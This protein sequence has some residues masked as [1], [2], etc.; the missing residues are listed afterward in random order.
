M[1]LCMRP[2]AHECGRHHSGVVRVSSYSELGELLAI[3]SIEHLS[4][5]INAASISVVYDVALAHEVLWFSGP[6]AKS[7]A[8]SSQQH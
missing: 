3:G 4:Q 2:R 1:V 5:A 6:I 7:K 8:I